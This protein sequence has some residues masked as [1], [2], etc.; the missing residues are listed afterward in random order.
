MKY[1]II[2][3]EASG[4]LHASNLMK[5]LKVLDPGAQFHCWGGDLMQAAGGELVKH[6]RSLAFMGFTEVLL[7]LRTI[8]GNLSFCKKDIAEYK[9]DVIILVDYPGFNLRV[10]K[11]AH[12]AGIKVFY[13]ISPQ[14]WAWKQSRVYS[15]QK[16]VDRMFVILPFEK[17]FYAR[18]GVEVEF[19][20]HPLH[21]AI[22]GDI[23]V[24]TE[25]DFR[26]MHG[27]CEKPIIAL[28]PGSRK[29][30]I[31]RVLPVMMSVVQ[32]FE[33][34]QFVVAGVSSVGEGFYN[35]ILEGSNAEIIFDKTR[36]LLRNSMAAL[37]TS[38]T[39]TLETAMIGIPQV[40]C[41][42]GGQLSYLIARQLIKV[43]YISLVNLIAGRRVVDELIQDKL[44]HKNLTQALNRILP[45]GDN[46]TRILSDYEELNNMLGS[47]KASE[48]AAKLMTGY[49]K[50]Q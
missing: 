26:N 13:Y 25:R 42:K 38:G 31:E 1:Y 35:K 4:D 34:Y 49:L 24:S 28:L 41:Y 7:N 20:G 44:N 19:V 46:R 11:Y 3:G 29:Q 30:E 47:E 39:A 23:S 48:R 15:I 14:V 43:A 2:A 12:E 37:V 36:T 18:F 16:Y 17:D 33:K 8:L 50:Q 22:A 45:E 27:L 5:E 21:D 6:Y 32:D 10:A 9:P 40:V